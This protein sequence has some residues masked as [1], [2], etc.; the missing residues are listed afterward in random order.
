MW[1]AESTVLAMTT[2]MKVDR[3]S[4][5]LNDGSGGLRTEVCVMCLFLSL[6]L[7]GGTIS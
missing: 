1:T 7:R 5:D 3:D 4:L 2:K 6:I